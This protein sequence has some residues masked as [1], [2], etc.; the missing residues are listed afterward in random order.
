MKVSPDYVLQSFKGLDYDQNS[1]RQR[2]Y[3]SISLTDFPTWLW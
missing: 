1:C 3:V 2:S